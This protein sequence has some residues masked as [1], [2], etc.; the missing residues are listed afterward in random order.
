MSVSLV[1]NLDKLYHYCLEFKNCKFTIN[2]PHHAAHKIIIKIFV[3]LIGNGIKFMDLRNM[4]SKYG[5]IKKENPIK[6]DEY[7][8]I[9]IDILSF[10]K[11]PKKIC[12]DLLKQ[13]FY[14]VI[15]F[16]TIQIQGKEYNAKYLSLK[17]IQEEIDSDD[18]KVDLNSDQVTTLSLVRTYKGSYIG[19]IKPI[20]HHEINSL[21]DASKRYKSFC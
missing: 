18:L 2:N 16:A 19:T 10:D 9:A 11:L 5:E 14:D 12:D 13:S 4:T 21:D 6:S 17:L 3:S 7:Y 15:D 1:T 20:S 8:V